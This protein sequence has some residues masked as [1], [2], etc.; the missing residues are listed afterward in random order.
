MN[1]FEKSTK[2]LK[3]IYAN[4]LN[5]EQPCEKPENEITKLCA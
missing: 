4:M 1:S 3:R 2:M 5:A